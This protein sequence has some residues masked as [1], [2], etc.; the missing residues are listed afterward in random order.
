MLPAPPQTDSSGPGLAIGFVEQLHGVAE[1][2]LAVAAHQVEHVDEDA[3]ADRVEDLV[4][5][6]AV[7]YDLATAENGE[8]LGEVGL[9]DFE[10]LLDGTGGELAVAQGLEDGDTGGVRQRLKEGRFVGSQL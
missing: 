3:V 5:F 4:A 2:L 1:V 6:L 7:H 8:M 9:L 10:A